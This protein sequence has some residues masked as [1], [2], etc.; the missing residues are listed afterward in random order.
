[1]TNDDEG[2][3]PPLPEVPRRP[4]PYRDMTVYE[5]HAESSNSPAFASLLRLSEVEAEAIE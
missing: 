1:M 2:F 5:R 3:Y 4:I